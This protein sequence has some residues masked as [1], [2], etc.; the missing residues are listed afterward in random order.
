M[1]D[2]TPT[3]QDVANRILVKIDAI[4]QEGVIQR[5][6]YDSSGEEFLH[7]DIPTSEKVLTFYVQALDAVTRYMAQIS[8]KIEGNA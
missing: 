1:S 2:N 3:P 5:V 4:L 7:Y 6:A 8:S